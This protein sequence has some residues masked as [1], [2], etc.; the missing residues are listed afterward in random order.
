MFCLKE[1]TPNA[2]A[3]LLNY[4]LNEKNLLESHIP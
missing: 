1:N 3:T 2:Y 4:F